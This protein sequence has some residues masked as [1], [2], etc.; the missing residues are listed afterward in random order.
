MI[1]PIL[2]KSQKVNFILFGKSVSFSDLQQYWIYSKK[3]LCMRKMLR[4]MPWENHHHFWIFNSIFIFAKNIVWIS[5]IIILSSCDFLRLCSKNL[6]F[7]IMNKS[8]YLN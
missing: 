6:N 4:L 7:D 5:A 1:D 3:K 2:E 8:S